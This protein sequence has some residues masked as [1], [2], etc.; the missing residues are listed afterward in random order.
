M[1][2]KRLARHGLAVSGAALSAVLSQR[3]ESAGVPS[4]VVSSTIKAAISA[5]AGKGI[6]AAAG[7]AGGVPVWPRRHLPGVND[8][9]TQS[10]MVPSVRVVRPL[11][12]P[13]PG[14][15][16][17]LQLTGFPLTSTVA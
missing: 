14:P 3:T 13:T 16:H 2:A 15:N 12:T 11:T 7:S 8:L 17:Q 1:L 5:A 10:A 4:R 6:A 9:R